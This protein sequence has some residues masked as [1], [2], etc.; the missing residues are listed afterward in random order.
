MLVEPIL[1]KQ[2]MFAFQQLPVPAN[3]FAKLSI[4][5]FYRRVLAVV[6]SSTLN[7][8]SWIYI[9]VTILWILTSFTLRF[10]VCSPVED[11]PYWISAGPDLCFPTSKASIAGLGSDLA[12]DVLIIIFPLPVVC[13]QDAVQTLADSHRSQ[14]WTLG[15]GGN[16]ESSVSSSLAWC[17]FAPSR[18]TTPT[19]PTK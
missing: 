14:S 10:F 3:G 8:I 15:Y 6:V 16:L 7:C 13:V 2:V 11:L 4:V 9:I 17:T 1:I 18:S 19:I 12:L 5:C